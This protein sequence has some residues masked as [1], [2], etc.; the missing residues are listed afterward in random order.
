MDGV[1]V[2]EREIFDAASQIPNADDRNAYLDSVC[3]TDPALRE[4]VEQLLRASEM[5]GS[6]L[7]TP[8]GEQLTP[9][10][11]ATDVTAVVSNSGIDS[12]ELVIPEVKVPLDFL[13]P[14]TKPG[15]LGRL[16][17]Y[18]V[19]EILGQGAFGT[20]LKAFDDK[21]HRMVAIKVMNSELAA[22]SPPRK[23]FLREAQSSAR[24]RHDNIVGIHDIQESPLPYL[25]MEF[26]PGV[27]LQQRL[28]Q[29]GPLD[30][31]DILRIGQQIAAGLA[32]AHAQ[33]MIHRDI[34]P[35]NILIESGVEERVKITDFGLAR[36]T[37]DA[38]LTQSGLI[39]GTPL[40]MAPEQAKGQTLDHRTD[41][42]SLGSVLYTMASGRPPFRAANTIA[43]LKRVCDD[44][45][46]PINEIIPETP[47][48][49]CD[50]ISKLHAKDPE[51]RFQSAKEVADVLGQHL[52]FIKE[53]MKVPRPEPID[54]PLKLESAQTSIAHPPVKPQ[55]WTPTTMLLAFI[56]GVLMIPVI[57]IVLILVALAVPA[58][59][60]A[61]S[62]KAPTITT[63]DPQPL[64]ADRVGEWTS[65]F[66]SRDFTGWKSNNHWQIQDGML[67]SRVTA[68]TTKSPA[69]LVTDRQDFRDFHA[70]MEIKINSGGDS[71]FFFR[72]GENGDKALQ[73]QITAEPTGIGSVLRETATVAKSM[74]TIPANTWAMMEVLAQGPQ[75]TVLVDGLVAAHWTDASSEIPAG[76]L[77]FEAGFAG[78]EI[79]IRKVEVKRLSASA[80]T[81]SPADVLPLTSP[82]DILTSPDYEWTPPENLGPLVNTTFNDNWPALTADKLRLIY[83]SFGRADTGLCEATRTRSDQPFGV[84][85]PLGEEFSNQSVQDGIALTGD[86]LVLVFGSTRPGG[87]GEQGNHNLWQA[88]RSSLSSPFSKPVC[89]TVLNT[90]GD[91]I[92][93]W[94]SSDG[95]TIW[96]QAV[97]RP[98]SRNG[99]YWKS[100]R[101]S[102]EAEFEPPMPLELPL[103]PG[104]SHYPH[105][106]GLTLSSDE[107]VLIFAPF[108]NLDGKGEHNLLMSVRPT[109]DAKF[110][111]PVSLG[112]VVNF[113][114]NN[115]FP[116]LSGDGSTLVFS[117]R[118]GDLS[119][120]RRV[121]KAKIKTT[122]VNTPAPAIAPFD[123]AAA[124]AHQE[125]W[126][127]H[128]GVPVEYTNALGMKFNLIPPG[129]FLMGATDEEIRQLSRDLEQANA[130]D[131]DK[132]VAR[133][134]GPQ[135]PVRLTQPYYLAAHEVTVGQYRTFI[136]ASR[137][138]PTIEQLG[139]K[140]FK[141]QDCAIEPNR[142][143]RAV[144]G[145]SW[146]DASAFCRW[147]SKEHG[148]KYDLPTEAQWEHA[149]R[150]GTT[151]L[152]S[153]GD[154]V[155][156][157][158]DYAVFGRE[159]FW[160]AEVVGTKKANP[161]GMMD[162][163][164]NADEW[165]RDWHNSEFYGTSPKDD[166]VYVTNPKD[167]NSGRVARGGT[168]HSTPWWTRSATRPWDFPAVPSN[169]K[170]F[171]PMLTVESVRQATPKS[172]PP[173]IAPFDATAAKAHQEAWAK[174]LGVPVEYTNSIGMK[175]RLIP[176]GEF[177]MGST[178]EE[179]VEA[180]QVAGG[181]TKWKAHLRSERPPRKMVISQ[182]FY[183]GVTEVTQEQYQQV[184]GNNPSLF[185]ASGSKA[186]HVAGLETSAFP[187]EAVTWHE[188][189][190][191]CRQLQ[192]R[193]HL[194]GT[195][196]YSLPTED[197]WE[198]ACRAGTASRYFT[199]DDGAQLDQVA[200]LGQNAD[201][202]PHRTGEL[203]ANA[204]G[205]HDVHGNVWEWTAD[206]WILPPNAPSE[207]PAGQRVLRGGDWTAQP[208]SCR[209]A[210]RHADLP[211][212]RYGSVG[213]R[214][215]LS[216][217]AVKASQ[218]RG[219]PQTP[220]V[221]TKQRFA[222]DEWIDVLPL[223][224]PQIDKWTVPQRTGK[225]AWYLERGEL[226]VER[227][228]LASKL[229]LPLDSD[230]P[231]YEC[232]LEVTRR[233]G[234]KGFNLN[235][236]TKQGEC[237]LV[238]D[239]PDQG[240][241]HLGSAVKGVHL[242][243]GPQIVTGQR[244]TFR[245]EVRRL[246]N[247]DQ[248][249]VRVNNTTVGEWTGDLGTLANTYREG[250]P[251][252]RRVSLWIL[253]GGNEFAFHKI[254]VRMLD[255]STA[256]TLRP[257]ASP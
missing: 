42:F 116:T 81:P 106:G 103:L 199:G 31:Q 151:T 107:R 64:P 96:F 100:R 18:E 147:A 92:Q 93:P 101:A 257:I 55:G 148:L 33:G 184:T 205:L 250:F 213:F 45:P 222:S 216:V 44:T 124:K 227:N 126:A 83:H 129:E 113:S 252:D 194:P 204:F 121:R 37:D 128:L 234:S 131:F 145:V 189:M 177:T 134:A 138:I 76:P 152:W 253:P 29:K 218:L 27:T 132:F 49:L 200:W 166:P 196:A 180:L 84:A 254:R 122:L 70:R 176:P 193:E 99:G 191:F 123:A 238:F 182:P 72:F 52:A 32:A 171:R 1:P 149:C 241:V 85:Q 110:G 170:G 2:T 58:Y 232:E 109:R 60:A 246:Q 239:A 179:T 104:V 174:H 71:G 105:M 159:S 51:D 82:Y 125:A 144:I 95:L 141:W 137:H 173:A 203:R 157:L 48:W 169:P 223:I 235:L 201:G 16:A 158:A 221:S 226:M 47:Q 118:E 224:D 228:A 36:A 240:G 13:Q 243:A 219:T 59:Q 167:K 9:R 175:F 80:A 69:M 207:L 249:T 114:P 15:S 86:G 209:S 74:I 112:P 190:Q 186:T 23:R 210:H 255:G 67:V 248:V 19:M 7:A 245:V 63:V 212:A 133:F 163:H 35:A 24:V 102:L 115:I 75:I 130:T 247:S 229:I 91:E 139:V 143:Q 231:A 111:P 117:D 156:Q 39:V 34:K 20:V 98:N 8:A 53:P 220:N 21:L 61:Q 155:A 233:A 6:F 10:E 108:Y 57:A 12:P 97:H 162:M 225:N 154:D 26:I 22:T 54:L 77:A 187:V 153:F 79:S 185:A 198:F 188:A 5:A 146:D 78:T 90:S 11:P 211:T 197:R 30:L 195:A 236:P 192:E 183:L 215:A 237:P 88:T 50:I 206:E 46:R 178:D 142:E 62:R 181:D 41:L 56:A 120:T 140:R 165:C 94:L 17:H 43:V 256:E 135:H 25:V 164:G 217:D 66:N 244:T 150:A 251:S 119:M 168:S 14:A 136:E 28:D 89:L 3:G 40:Y 208:T 68:T 38:S 87:P 4:Q 127:K 172:P 230:W 242:K 160:P 65:L 214:V 202:R 73:A 161:F